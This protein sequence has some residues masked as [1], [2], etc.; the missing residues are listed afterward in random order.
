MQFANDIVLKTRFLILT[1]L[2]FFVFQL[3][4]QETTDR[5][6]VLWGDKLFL[7][8][9][10]VIPEIVGYDE[11]GFYSLVQDYRWAIEH[12]DTALGQARREYPI[13]NYGFW[14]RQMEKLVHF[15]GVLYLFT[16]EERFNSRILYVQTI[17][18]KTLKQI[19]EK[20]IIEVPDLRGWRADFHI[21]LSRL[22]Q[23]VL[24]VSRTIIFGQKIQEI[25]FLVFGENMEKEWESGDRI[26]HDKKIYYESEFVVDETGNAYM[27]C[28]YFQPILLQHLKPRKNSYLIVA[29][30]DHGEKVNRY[31]AD[32]PNKYIRGIGIEP[33]L[34]NN[35]AC[36]GFYS[37]SLIDLTI[38]GLFFFTIDHEYQIIRNMKFHELA[39]YFLEESM[40]LK[41]GQESKHLYNFYL[42]HLVLRQN[43]NFIL[44]GEQVLEQRYD[45]HANIIVMG[46]SPEGNVLW[47][48]VIQKLQNHD[49]DRYPEYVRNVAFDPYSNYTPNTEFVTYPN[50]TSYALF[51][52]PH[53]NRV[54][55]LFNENLKNLNRPAEKE[56]LTFHANSKAYLSCVEIGE[57]GEMGKNIIYIK[58]RKRNLTPAPIYFYDMKTNEMIMPALRYR[59]FRFMKLTFN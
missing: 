1:S 39:P 26:E 23:K 41:P 49:Y 11:T 34:D 20:V 53:W 52:P 30:T 25:R 46:L 12:Y 33:T 16:S 55:I 59:K 32:F 17:D 48:R 31:F 9:K 4:A 10:N 51:A 8:I 14:T 15:H 42:D 6:D 28:L 50:Y 44:S 27:I 35:L 5:V 58:K 7:E 56:M 54:E 3:N 24:V 19:D 21:T 2:I 13:M 43:G 38:D 29:F 18:K 36:A 45:N 57:Y 22:E 40:N 37:P 47:E